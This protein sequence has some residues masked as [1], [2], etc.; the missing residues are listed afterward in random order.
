MDEYDAHDDLRVVAE[1]AAKHN[2]N[3]PGHVDV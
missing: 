3:P 1:R 2:N